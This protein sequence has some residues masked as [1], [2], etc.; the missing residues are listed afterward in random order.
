MERLLYRMTE[1]AEFLGVSRSKTFE[2]VRSGVLPSVKV[3]GC[4]RVRAND[5]RIFVDSLA[6][7]AA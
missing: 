4:R 5:L 7:E 1:A 6:T 3:D 2:L